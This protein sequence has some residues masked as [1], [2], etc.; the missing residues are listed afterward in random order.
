MTALARLIIALIIGPGVGAM[1]GQEVARAL[2]SHFGLQGGGLVRA[3]TS[4]LLAGTLAGFVFFLLA[5]RSVHA[6]NGRLRARIADPALLPT[7]VLA[8][9]ALLAHQRGAP[10]RILAA[11]RWT[12]VAAWI[13]GLLLLSLSLTYRP[14]RVPELPCEGPP[15]VESAPRSKMRSRE[16]E[17]WARYVSEEQYDE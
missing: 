4:G 2:G 11:L 9:I 13:V 15:E 1:T 3:E 10:D 8:A 6:F 14:G 16:E 5:V 7:G 12:I 17:T